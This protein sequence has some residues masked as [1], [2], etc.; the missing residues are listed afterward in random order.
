MTIV[1]RSVSVMV[2][3][4]GQ[5]VLNVSVGLPPSDAYLF[6]V[7]ESD[8]LGLWAKIEREDGL[9]HLLL[10]WEYILSVDIRAGEGKGLGFQ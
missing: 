8:D 9:H 10:R 6:V 2:S 4:E 3:Q 7:D 5:Q 1:Q